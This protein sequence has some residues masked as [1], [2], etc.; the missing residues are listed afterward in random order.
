MPRKALVAGAAVAALSVGIAGAVP[1]ARL[2]IDRFEN[3][4][5]EDLDV[6]GRRFCVRGIGLRYLDEG[7]GFPIVLIHG[8]GGSAYDYRTVI[9]ALAERFRVIAVDLPG[10]GY[11]D[12]DSAQEISGTAWVEVL[13]EFL[14]RLGVTRAVFV[15]HSLGGAVVERFAASHSAMV[16]R[17]VLVAAVSA[18][19]RQR[20]HWG[21]V[22]D[23]ITT[24]VQG[25]LSASGRLGKLAQARTVHDPSFM[26]GTVLEGH[27]QPLRV[28]GSAAAVRRLFRGSAIDKPVDLAALTMPTLLLWGESDKVVRLAVATKLLDALPHA[29]LEVV[30]EAGHLVLEEQPAACRRILLD[31]LGDLAA[32][33][34]SRAGTLAGAH[35]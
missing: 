9:P 23:A 15:G 31:F 26:T 8:F 20:M 28:R 33:P 35:V 24:L 2:A 29:R 32:S 14:Q 10:F 21:A 16:E 7:T 22:A 34:S 19:D 5:L 6:P 4:E 11:S 17:L 25:A 13:A 18:A 30:A 27:L 1:L 12:R 3:L